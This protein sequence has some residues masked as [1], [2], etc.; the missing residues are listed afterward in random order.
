MS[1]VRKRNEHVG[2]GEFDV[3]IDDTSLIS[4]YFSISELPETFPQGKTPFKI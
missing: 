4:T 2:L 1:A 3:L